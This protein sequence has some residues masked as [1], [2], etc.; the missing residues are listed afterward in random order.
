[1]LDFNNL[2]NQELQVEKVIFKVV[3]HLRKQLSLTMA[4]SLKFTT[5]AAKK[6]YFPESFWV[7]YCLPPLAEAVDNRLRFTLLHKTLLVARKQVTLAEA[8]ST[9][10][11]SMI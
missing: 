10:E 2:T 9:S 1:M 5:Q 8:M 11:G 3:C 6:R 7:F 4:D